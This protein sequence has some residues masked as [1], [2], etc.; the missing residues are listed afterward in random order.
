MRGVEGQ[1][2]VAMRWGIVSP[3]ENNGMLAALRQGL[4]GR[5]ELGFWRGGGITS[6]IPSP[7]EG[8]LG[9]SCPLYDG[10]AVPSALVLGNEQN[11]ES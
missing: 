6:R 1:D 2:L 9:W 4:C 3:S 10:C 7:G 5:R 11:I 8:G